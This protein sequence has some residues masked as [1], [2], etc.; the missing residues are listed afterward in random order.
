MKAMLIEKWDNKGQKL[1][2][3]AHWSK[4]SF[5]AESWTSLRDTKDSRSSSERDGYFG[6]YQ[7]WSLKD[8]YATGK[9]PM[10]LEAIFDKERASEKKNKRRLFG[11]ESYF[12][13]GIR[14][15]LVKNLI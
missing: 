13:L 11:H 2:R 5:L 10:N 6:Y 15:A 1:W 12:Q 9:A 8:R 7:I 4:K 3:E 14:S